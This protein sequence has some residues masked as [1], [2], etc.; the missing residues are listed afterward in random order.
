[1]AG[2]LEGRKALITGASSG[3]GAGIATAFA[4]EGADIVINYPTG[5]EES[6]AREVA[7]AVRDAGRQ[8]YP[9]EGDVSRRSPVRRLVRESIEKLGR[10]DILVNNA[11][12]VSRAPVHEMPV[13]MWDEMIRVNLRSVFLVTRQVLPHMY[14]Q[15]SGKIVNTASQR[16]YV[17][18]AEF[19]HYCAAKAGIIAF[20]RSL[21]REIGERD[22][23]ANCVAPGATCTRL[24]DGFDASRLGA[25]RATIPKGALA[26]VDQIVPAYVF[27]A[28]DEASHMVG[29]TVSP[30]GGDVML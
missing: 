13:V 10:I 9:I 26:R 23:N 25:L 6:A 2:R 7:A 3:I 22:I 29:Q 30:N 19:G 4:R 12:I 15:G 16:A 1:M 11:G 28:S 27:L 21:S 17:G 8:A 18:S 14:R 24:L 20:T 5:N